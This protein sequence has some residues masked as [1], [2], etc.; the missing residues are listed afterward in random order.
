MIGANWI[1]AGSVTMT[2]L[3][4][5]VADCKSVS[6]SK[7]DVK[8]WARFPGQK[9]G[10]RRRPWEIR[11]VDWTAT[12]NHTTCSRHFFAWRN[13]TPSRKY[14]DP[15][16]FLHNGWGENNISHNIRTINALQRC[17]NECCAASDSINSGH[18]GPV[19][20]QEVASSVVQLSIL[21][22]VV[23]RTPSQGKE[24]GT[25]VFVYVLLGKTYCTD[26]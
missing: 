3:V 4:Y 5:A 8:E 17:S 25:R 1:A 24:Q 7:H 2:N 10:K 23:S 22:V 12:R 9:D 11:D 16:L 26:I 21:V 15:V 14:P 13:G 19:W 6:S 20:K 18:P